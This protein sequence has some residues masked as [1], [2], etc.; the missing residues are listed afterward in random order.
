MYIVSDGSSRPYRCKI[1]APGFAHLVSPLCIS[2]R[3]LNFKEGFISGL[4]STCRAVGGGGCKHEHEQGAK[5][6]VIIRLGHYEYPFCARITYMGRCELTLH[7]IPT[8][9]LTLP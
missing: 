2:S 5:R 1:K 7:C 3:E 8:E 6:S 4:K 9:S